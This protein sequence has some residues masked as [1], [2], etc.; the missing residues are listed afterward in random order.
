L[1]DAD[2][3]LWVGEEPAK[4]GLQAKIGSLSIMNQRQFEFLDRQFG[5]QRSVPCKHI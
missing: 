4:G 2:K 1:D 5:I 3:Q